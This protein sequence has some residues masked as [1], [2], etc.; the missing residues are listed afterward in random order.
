M[1]VL[2]FIWRRVLA[3]DRIGSRIPQLIQIWLLELFFALP[4][5]FFVG[6]AIDIHGALGVPGT[7]G[8][9]PAPSGGR[10]SS[11]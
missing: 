11:P 3:F 1:G 7:G 8:R 2:R 4:L 9:C 10:S 6:K 5:A